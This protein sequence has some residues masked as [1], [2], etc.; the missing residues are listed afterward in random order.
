[1]VCLSADSPVLW[2]RV[3]PDMNLLSHVTW[4]QP[5]YMWQYQLRYERD[6]VAQREVIMEN[7]IYQFAFIS[8]KRSLYFISRELHVTFCFKEGVLNDALINTLFS[9]KGKQKNIIST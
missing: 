2:L 5:D 9:V 3:D 6:I 4:E 7:L 1:M 8:L